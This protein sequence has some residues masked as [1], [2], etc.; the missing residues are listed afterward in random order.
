MTKS[1][2]IP[3]FSFNLFR[4][5][6]TK[7]K[8]V[9]FSPYSIK[10]CMALLYE[11]ARGA[12]EAQMASVFGFSD[13]FTEG[14]KLHQELL[15]LK[16]AKGSSL[17][18]RI[19]NSIW[20][21]Q[22][23]ALCPEYVEVV[24]G[25]YQAKVEQADFRN[26]AEEARRAINAW[27][28]EETLGKIR[29]ILPPGSVDQLTKLVLVNAIYFKGKWA[30]QFEPR[31]TKPA[32]FHISPAEKVTVPLMTITDDFGY[33]EG[34]SGQA[35]ELP[36]VGNKLSMVVLLPKPDQTLDFLE[37]NLPAVLD[38]VLPRL[39]PQERVR[40]FLPKFKLETQY[41][42]T[43]TLSKMGMVNAFTQKA[44]FSGL[45]GTADNVVSIAVHK[46]FVEVNE[47]GTEAAAA[48]AAA[49]C[50]ST[51]FSPIPDFRADRP[52][53]FLI[54]DRETG[55]ILFLGRFAKP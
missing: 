30:S 16:A 28:A 38:R 54:R 27:V 47:E 55:A 11:G 4:Q 6:G 29:D 32:P 7:G 35:V 45:D 31:H 3:T 40:V 8:N 33:T 52:F 17:A 21:D 19:A 18:L 44:D 36:Y 12:T 48:T 46:A 53:V 39:Q 23:T 43:D 50:R 41:N 22:K 34:V 9:F 14:G 51:S 2:N 42:L 49:V 24:R 10:A 5:V 26:A 20:L 13:R 25:H 1:P 15:A 37:A